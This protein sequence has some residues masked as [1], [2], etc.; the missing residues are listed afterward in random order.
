MESY[1]KYLV[2][3]DVFHYDYEFDAYAPLWNYSAW[4]SNGA[5]VRF[6]REKTNAEIAVY[7][8]CEDT[9]RSEGK[10]EESR[11]ASK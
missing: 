1:I 8:S 10:N 9:K 2:E 6:V 4:T 7:D 11:K 5:P 3:G